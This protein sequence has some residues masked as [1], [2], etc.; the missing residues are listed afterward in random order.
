LIAYLF[1]STDT[2]YRDASTRFFGV[3]IFSTY[4]SFKIQTRL[5]NLP[6]NSKFIELMMIVRPLLI[7]SRYSQTIKAMSASKS[8]VGSSRIKISGSPNK[9]VA[10][11][12]F[13]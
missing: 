2:K 9:A 10:N 13:L 4:P 6:I 7:E 11:C 8:A 12:T 1:G 3:S 5:A